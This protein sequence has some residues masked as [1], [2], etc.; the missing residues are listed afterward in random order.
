MRTLLLL[1]L[2]SITSAAVAADVSWT[3]F[4]GKVKA[5]DQKASRITI[6]NGEGDLIGVKVDEDVSIVTGKEKR[7]L[8][9]IEIDDKIVLYYLPKAPVPKD[10]EEPA[11]GDVYKP[12]R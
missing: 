11:P 3:R 4:K 9:E 8:K 12:S 10:P 1:I 2:T 7:A 5:I 6:Q